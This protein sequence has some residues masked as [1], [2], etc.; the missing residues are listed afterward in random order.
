MIL[1][2]SGTD[3][4][5]LD[6]HL[7]RVNGCETFVDT[8]WSWVSLKD[9]GVTTY[10]TVRIYPPKMGTAVFLREETTIGFQALPKTSQVFSSPGCLR[11]VVSVRVGQFHKIDE[12]LIMVQVTHGILAWDGVIP[13]KNSFADPHARFILLISLYFTS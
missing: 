7:I 13:C 9:V 6:T 4:K 2:A 12:L 3:I 8:F 5:G 11:E 10:A 1:D